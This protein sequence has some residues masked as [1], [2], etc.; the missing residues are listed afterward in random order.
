MK[1]DFQEMRWE[2]GIDLFQDCN[3]WRALVKK[4]IRF[5]AL[6]ESWTLVE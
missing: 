5:E 2:D 4:T 6:F 3:K 1:V